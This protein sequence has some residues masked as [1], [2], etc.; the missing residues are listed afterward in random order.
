M[1]AV[2]VEQES[3]TRTGW[4]HSVTLTLADGSV[5]Q[6]TVTLC[7][8]DYEYWSGGTRPP[9]RVTE[10]LIECL[11]DPDEDA[12]VPEPLPDRFDASTARR[13]MPS[14]DSCLRS[15]SWH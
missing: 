13:W 1:T 7:F 4:T 6:L 3:Q 2:R 9:E 15:G 10:A 11:L 5:Q 8:Q 14:L 12:N